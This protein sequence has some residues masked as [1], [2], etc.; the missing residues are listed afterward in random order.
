MPGFSLKDVLHVLLGAHHYRI[1]DETLLVS[2][3]DAAGGGG[4]TR[5]GGNCGG[6]RKRNEI[7]SL[8]IC[9]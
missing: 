6:Q 9:F 8:G 5:N 4:E 7:I 1:C 3:R 2:L